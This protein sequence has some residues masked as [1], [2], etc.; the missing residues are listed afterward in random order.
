MN[1]KHILFPAIIIGFIAACS[2]SKKTSKTTRKGKGILTDLAKTAIK[3][4]ANKGIDMGANF[5]KD[6]VSGMGNKRFADAR[7]IRGRRPPPMKKTFGGTGVDNVYQGT[8]LFPAGVGG[9][10][11]PA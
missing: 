8:A 9:A 3:S 5:L 7:R 4:V 6:K 10:L 11:Y 1:Y 2:S